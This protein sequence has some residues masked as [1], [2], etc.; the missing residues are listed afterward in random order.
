MGAR[1]VAAIIQVQ[2]DLRELVSSC[3]PG[4]IAENVFA[5]RRG[6]YVFL[7]NI[8]DAVVWFKNAELAPY[9]TAI[10]KRT[11]TRSSWCITRRRSPGA[12]RNEAP[13]GEGRL[14]N[15]RIPPEA[16]IAQA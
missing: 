2:A 5:S 13:D 14:G 8:S 1:V 16:V 9:G 6:D 3:W 11:A 7:Q 15:R 4:H 12:R 10:Y